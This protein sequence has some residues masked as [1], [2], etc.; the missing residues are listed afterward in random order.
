MRFHA[1]FASLWVGLADRLGGS[2][3]TLIC[4]L[5]RYYST[6]FTA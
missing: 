6:R 3:V 5:F 1:D 4:R 2:G